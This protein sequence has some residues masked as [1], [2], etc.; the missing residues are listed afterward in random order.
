LVF[1]ACLFFALKNLT[2]R[3]L[4]LWWAG[5]AF[6][7]SILSGMTLLLADGWVRG[8]INLENPVFLPVLGHSLPVL[9]VYLL[10]GL[11]IW[12]I[13]VRSLKAFDNA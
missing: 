8:M 11:G 5:A 9:L 1:A 10:A 2:S 3:S 4:R 7:G 13:S 6:L 12:F